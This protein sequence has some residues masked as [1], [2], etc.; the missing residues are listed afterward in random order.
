MIDIE[1]RKLYQ[2]KWLCTAFS[3]S[4]SDEASKR[5]YLFKS[6]VL[7]LVSGHLQGLGHS[8][9]KQLEFLFCFLFSFQQKRVSLLSFA[10]RFSRWSKS[11]NFSSSSS[12]LPKSLI[13]RWELPRMHWIE[14]LIDRNMRTIQRD[15]T[16]V[17][18]R[19]VDRY[20]TK[21]LIQRIFPPARVYF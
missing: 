14:F 19:T 2:N 4:T 10:L 21:E 9:R 5:T 1:K 13:E 20:G 3:S 8:A 12:C 15:W 6:L 18:R 11:N 17:E 7:P 16:F